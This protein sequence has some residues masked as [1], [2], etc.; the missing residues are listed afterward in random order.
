MYPARERLCG[1][2]SVGAQVDDRLVVNDD[3]VF[4]YRGRQLISRDRLG[5]SSGLRDR[6]QVRDLLEPGAKRFQF[7]RFL[8][9]HE[10]VESHGTAEICRCCEQALVH[11]AHQHD[12]CLGSPVRKEPQKFHAINLLHAQIEND[13]VW[14]K[15]FVGGFEPVGLVQRERLV[16]ETPC[17]TLDDPA[18]AR[19]IIHHQQPSCG[20]R[21]GLPR[22]FCMFVVCLRRRRSACDACLLT[23]SS[24]LA[25][26]IALTGRDHL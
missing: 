4:L 2:Q 26:L 1:D 16:A 6:F 18:R 19:I 25:V 7:H 3:L 9:R 12:L 15:V 24:R 11:S 22:A 17:N 23:K 10:H 21:H 8:H 13:D 5:A 14:L 20:R